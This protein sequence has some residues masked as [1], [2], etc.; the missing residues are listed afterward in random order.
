MFQYDDEDLI[1]DLQKIY[2]KFNPRQYIETP[3]ES[4]GHINT[5][6]SS[7]ISVVTSTT[8]VPTPGTKLSLLYF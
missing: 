7:F 6:S 8:T 3:E 4:I 5:E 2:T 1:P